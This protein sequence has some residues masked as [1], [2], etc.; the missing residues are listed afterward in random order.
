VPA[1]LRSPAQR[2]EFEMEM[3]VLAKQLG[4][5]L[6]EVPIETV[7]IDGN[8][9]SHFDPLRDSFRIYF[10]LVRFSALAISSAALDFALFSAVFALFHNVG[11]SILV[12][13]LFSGVYNF[14]GGKRW[15]FRS[16]AAAPQEAVRYVALALVLMGLSYCMIT[17]L[18]GLLKFNV[19][20]AKVLGEGLLFLLSFSVQNQF[21]FRDR[22]GRSV[23]A[24]P[25]PA[26]T[27]GSSQQ[28]S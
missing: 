11:V 17:T 1:L 4:H 18:V 13:R 9:M 19:L 22:N 3:F 14:F 6:R 21:V 12:A 16:Q 2:Y 8:R 28:A 23:P 26:E 24:S 25:L 5:A 15:V 7:Y 10:V 27:A 20:A